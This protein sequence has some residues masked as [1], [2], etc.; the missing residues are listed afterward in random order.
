MEGYILPCFSSH[1]RRIL[2]SAVCPKRVLFLSSSS[3]FFPFPLVGDKRGLFFT[4]G[5][6]FYRNIHPRSKREA[7]APVPFTCTGLGLSNVVQDQRLLRHFGVEGWG[8][9]VDGSVGLLDPFPLSHLHGGRLD[10]GPFFHLL[11][12]AF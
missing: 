1:F 11:L 9:G 4:N 12:T 8:G 10:R 6:L 3:C 7:L 2:F 5:V